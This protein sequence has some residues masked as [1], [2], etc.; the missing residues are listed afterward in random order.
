MKRYGNLFSKITDIDNLRLAHKNARKGKIH[1]PSVVKV[2]G[3]TDEYLYRIQKMLIEGTYHTS[4][5]KMFEIYDKGKKREICNL[6]YFPDRIVHWAL[7]Q[8]IKPILLKNMIETTYAALPNKGTHKAYKKLNKYMNDRDGTQYCLK[9]D[10][11]KFFPSINK[12][13][14]KQRFRTKIK[15]KNTIWLL[16]ELIDS[17]KNGIPIGNYT[18]QYF[19]NFY[20]SEFDHWLKEQKK[21]RYYLRYMDDMVILSNSKEELHQLRKDIQDYLKTKLKLQLKE[22]WQ[23]FPTYTRGI[24]FVGYRSFGDFT[25]LR[26]STKKRLKRAIAIIYKSVKKGLE[27]THSNKCTVASYSGVLLW[28]NSY[29]LSNKTIIDLKK[30]INNRKVSKSRR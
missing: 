18:S 27:I 20:L 11:K 25:L 26:N 12:D 5:C 24:D 8:I 28:C 7:M 14:L 9:M 13:I 15:C 3:N 29:R 4:K 22:N 17:Y 1:Y 30:S 21:V 23:V 6:P 16:D 10:I 19:G 2:D